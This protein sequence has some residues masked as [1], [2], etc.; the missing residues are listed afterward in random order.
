MPLEKAQ[1]I[2]DFF[3]K[4]YAK[5]NLFLKIVGQTQFQNKMYHLLQTRF[6]RVQNLY[7]TL[8]FDFDAENFEIIGEF[9]CP[10]QENL[11]YKAYQALLP[12]I[13][14]AKRKDLT[15]T[16]VS[17]KK[18]IPTKGG[19]GGGS[20][21]AAAFLKGINEALNLG[22]SQESLMQIGVQLGSD[23]A[24]FISDL[25]IA[26]AEGRGEILTPCKSEDTP[27]AVRLFTPKVSCESARIFQKY[28]HDFYDANIAKMESF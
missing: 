23:V 12:H 11:I 20:S 24:F 2:C 15:H 25:D 6:L 13:K 26:N 14:P 28:A 18:C 9:D 19:L 3:C 10:L 22:L 17:V 21:N 1:N 4:S 27:F 7:D 5:V 16:R 8:E